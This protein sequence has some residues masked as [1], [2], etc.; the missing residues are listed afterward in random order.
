MY[1]KCSYLECVKTAVVSS[2]KTADLSSVVERHVGSIHGA[3][4]HR[5][6][7]TTGRIATYTSYV[8]QLSL[9]SGS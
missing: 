4:S 6:P 3:M 9:G 8:A 1:L 7:D 2:T 5:P